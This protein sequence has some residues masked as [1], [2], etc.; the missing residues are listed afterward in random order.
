[1]PYWG[2]DPISWDRLYVNGQLAPGWVSNYRVTRRVKLQKNAG[3]G[4]RGASLVLQG[5]E[6]ADVSFEL[7][8]RTEHQLARAVA[9]VRDRIPTK[10]QKSAV[11]CAH[12]ILTIHQLSLLFLERLGGPHR[13]EHGLYTIELELVEFAPPPKVDATQPISAVK[14]GGNLLDGSA[15]PLLD[16]PAR[17]LP[18]LP[19]FPPLSPPSAA[20]PK[21]PGK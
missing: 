14:L 1:V 15:G 17:K 3:P 20:V 19:T 18:P 16:S 13:K 12:P 2:T 11:A 5:R 4:T 7:M 9:F 21:P 8:L 10:D 6:L